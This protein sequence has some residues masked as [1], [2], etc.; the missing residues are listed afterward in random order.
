MLRCHSSSQNDVPADYATVS[1]LAKGTMFY[2]WAH[3]QGTV[4][5]G[6]NADDEVPW[7]VIILFVLA[8]YWA[9]GVLKLVRAKS[10]SSSLP[11][12]TAHDG[13]S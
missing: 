8:S 7:R 2:T 9:A 1:F 10:R 3:G 5:V 11:L 4:Q 12:F 6:A 13:C